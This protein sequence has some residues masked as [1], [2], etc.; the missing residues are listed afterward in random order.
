MA[1]ALA[2][3]WFKS[4]Q[5]RTHC[6][7]KCVIEMAREEE[8]KLGSVKRPPAWPKRFMLGSSR[9]APHLMRAEVE[10]VSIIMLQSSLK[11][12]RSVLQ[13]GLVQSHLHAPRSGALD[14]KLLK[15]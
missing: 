8:V 12:P 5:A 9:N 11:A 6:P 4:P 7:R 2:M 15:L 13:V 10:E 3:D 14:H 1:N